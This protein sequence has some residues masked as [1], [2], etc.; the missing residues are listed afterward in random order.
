MDWSAE[1]WVA[2]YDSD[3]QN[4]RL[5][6]HVWDENALDVPE[7]FFSDLRGLLGAHCI[8]K[9]VA[10]FNRACIEHENASVRRSCA[11]SLTE[12][13]EHWPGK[14]TSIVKQL[15]DAFREK[16]RRDVTVALILFSD[17]HLGKSHWSR[18]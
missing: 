7:S 4:A 5:A 3:E 10:D 12:A 14:I 1:L 11:D 9:L 8:R 17:F 16:V 18:I 2:R 6:R 13:A 15:Q